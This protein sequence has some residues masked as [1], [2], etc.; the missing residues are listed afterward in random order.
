MNDVLN[1]LTFLFEKEQLG[2]SSINT[3]RGALSAMCIKLDGTLAGTHPLVIRFL[4]GVF[5]LRPPLQTKPSHV[6]DVSIVTEY[7]RKLSPVKELSLKDLTLKHTMLIAL[8]TAARVQSIHLLSVNN[9]V[10]GKDEFVFKFGSL[11]KQSRPGFKSASVHLKAYP[12]DRRL[13]IYFVVKEYLKRTKHIRKGDSLFI[14]F[15]KPH[16]E[17]SRDTIARWIKTVM[18][19]AGIDVTKFSAHSVR[20][21]STSKAML[22]HVPMNEILKMA[23]WSNSGTFA[24]FYNKEV[25]SS[26]GKFETAVLKT[27]SH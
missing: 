9:M 16:G 8:T 18:F 3:A 2:Y 24:R 19:K 21:A 26:K 17:V 22:N 6:W 11:L 15:V 14:S 20:S 23:G 10:K 4:K 27:T 5:N 12:P 25:S 13:C 1:F 7:L